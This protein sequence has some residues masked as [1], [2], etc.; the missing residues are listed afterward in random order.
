EWIADQRVLALG[1]HSAGPR[2]AQR[3][4]SHAL[5]DLPAVVI[6]PGH[7]QPPYPVYLSIAPTPRLRA[8]GESAAQRKPTGAAEYSPERRLAFRCWHGRTVVRDRRRAPTAIGTPCRQPDPEYAAAHSA[9]GP[10]TQAADGVE[11][12]RAKDGAAVLNSG[13]R[14]P[15]RQ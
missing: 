4:R 15:D 5:G 14:P 6:G 13:E 7:A 10:C 8:I 11:L 9:R 1:L 3:R 12:H 2:H